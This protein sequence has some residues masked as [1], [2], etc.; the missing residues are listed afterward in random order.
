MQVCLDDHTTSSPS[1]ST[2]ASIDYVTGT[3]LYVLNIYVKLVALEWFD[4]LSR[5]LVLCRFPKEWKTWRHAESIKSGFQECAY[6]IAS[7]LAHII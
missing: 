4:N 5:M 1:S 6:L 2:L 7:M 3:A